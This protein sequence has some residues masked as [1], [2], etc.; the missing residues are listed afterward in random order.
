[1][2]NVTLSTDISTELD[3]VVVA[4]EDVRRQLQSLPTGL[5]KG[6]KSLDLSSVKYLKTVISRWKTLEPDF[7][8]RV[9]LYDWEYLDTLD[10]V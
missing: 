9:S 1:V 4:Y 7:R 5:T 8:G 2:G 3:T 6:S 10:Q